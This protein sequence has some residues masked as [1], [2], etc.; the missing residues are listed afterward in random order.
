V[1]RAGV[2]ITKHDE[3]EITA[4]IDRLAKLSR[5]Q[6]DHTRKDAAEKLGIGVATLDL[7]VKAARQKNGD[8]KGQGRPLELPE[9]KPWRGAINGSELL[10]EIVACLRD[11]LV[12]PSGSAEIIALWVLHTHV[13]DCFTITPR[14]AITSPEKGCGKTTLLDV[15]H[16][17]AAR[18]LSTSSATTSAVFRI[19]EMKAPTL[20]IDEA[21]TFLK[22]NDE[23][24]GVLNTGHRRGGQVTR[25]VGEDFEPRQ[26]TT[27]SPAAIA[28][29]G[30]LPDTLDDRA[31]TIRL[32]RRKPIERVRAFRSDR[33]GELRVL[34]QKAARW[35]LDNRQTLTAADP[36]TGELV[37]RSADN[38]RPL[39]AIADAA[40]GRW[41]R[42]ARSTAESAEAA[43]EDQSIKTMLLSDIRDVFTERP[44]S[45]RIS[46]NELAATLGAMEGRP[47]ADWRNGKPMT[48]SGLARMLAPFGILP[49]TKR[50]GS[51]T[52]KGYLYSDFADAFA[53]YL[54]DQTV[55]SSQPNSHG[56]CDALQT[57]TRENLVTL[58]KTSQPNS[59]GHCDGVT[60][61]SE[62][63]TSSQHKCDHCQ[64]YGGA[65]PFAYGST[66]GWVH[67]DCMDPWKAAYD[68]LDIRN[69]PFYRPEP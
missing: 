16:Q 38:W 30:R 11:Y 66:E 50:T 35:A 29:I 31:I 39:F 9:I 58:S 47:W 28:M 13:F 5:V 56:H 64:Q 24:R 15:I 59:H 23:L 55:T 45:D 2:Q 57:V 33:A 34:A 14:L 67:R 41:S 65:M 51:D 4:E 37:N 26:F 17:L 7:E 60:V 54:P 43:K 61:S 12:L 19:V 32:R 25:T 3:A 53:S 36:E 40:G 69:Q 21:D 63:D 44:Y 68:A 27:W 48:A 18:S 62:K 8:T 49:G 42:L 52:F 20:L 22:D 6:Y 46:S 1:T 10:D